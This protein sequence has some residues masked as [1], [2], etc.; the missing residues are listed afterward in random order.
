MLLQ[1]VLL[2]VA[3]HSLLQSV[4]GK[5]CC[6]CPHSSGVCGAAVAAHQCSPAGLRWKQVTARLLLQ[7]L[8]SIAFPDLIVLLR[9]PQCTPYESHANEIGTSQ[10]GSIGSTA[11]RESSVKVFHHRLFECLRPFPFWSPGQLH[12]MV[13]FLIADIRRILKKWF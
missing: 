8:A 11:I 2:Q 3:C 7:G 10:Y 13:Y 9:T 1:S 12:S 4:L 6:R 5:T